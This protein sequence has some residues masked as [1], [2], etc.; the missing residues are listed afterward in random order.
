MPRVVHFEIYADELARATKFYSEVFGW[1]MH[2]WDGPDDYWLAITGREGESGIDGAITGR[3]EFGF[4]GVNFI[5]VDSVDNFITKIQ[6]NGGTLVRPKIAIPEVGYSAVC[7]DT[8]GNP[9]GLFQVD[10]NAT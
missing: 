1:D 3:P 5:D 9:I 4:T 2:K 7:N 8:E 6:A 10:P